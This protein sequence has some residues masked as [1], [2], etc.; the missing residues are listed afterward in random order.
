MI[1]NFWSIPRSVLSRCAQHRVLV[2]GILGS[3][4]LV[5][6]KW[7]SNL[8]NKL[9]HLPKNKFFSTIFNKKNLIGVHMLGR[10]LAT[11]LFLSSFTFL[12]LLGAMQAEAEEVLETMQAEK[13]SVL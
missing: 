13:E 3:T 7:P 8:Q 10:Y 2:I 9:R 1:S 4:G 6:K 11:S 5:L 12:E